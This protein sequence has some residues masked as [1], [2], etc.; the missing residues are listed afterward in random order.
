MHRQAQIEL[1]SQSRN[2]SCT[3]PE[4]RG[5]DAQSLPLAVEKPQ[6][7]MEG[8]TAN[9]LWTTNF[10]LL[11]HFGVYVL[12]LGSSQLFICDTEISRRSC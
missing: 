2:V 5:S 7:V 3:E 11:I 10:S 12:E 1:L 9:G 4:D 6:Q 8:C